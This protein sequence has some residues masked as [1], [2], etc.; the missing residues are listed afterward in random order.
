MHQCSFTL[1]NKPMSAF[2]IGSLSFPAFSG[3]AGHANQRSSACLSGLGPIPPGWYYIFGRQSGGR[4]GPLWDLL[5]DR[6]EWFALHAID[7]RI[8]DEAY[9]DEVRRGAFRL[10]PNG[11]Q[12]ISHGCIVIESLCNFHHL[13]TILSSTA[14]QPVG[15]T[16]LKA[17]G[18]VVVQ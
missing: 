3:L 13:R 10:H 12:G 14:A 8:D 15:G 18:R 9:C 4:L 2:K 6:S 7:S 11:V 5:D 16:S 1:N 17:Y